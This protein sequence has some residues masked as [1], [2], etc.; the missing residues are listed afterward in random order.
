MGILFLAEA[1]YN[2]KESW[3]C[4]F[5]LTSRFL[6]GDELLLPVRPCVSDLEA[7]EKMSMAPLF[8]HLSF[9]TLNPL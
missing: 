3:R 2:M 4:V 8:S 6:G 5:L 9:T 7:D 1:C